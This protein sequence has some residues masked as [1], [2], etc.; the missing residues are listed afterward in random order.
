M[1]NWKHSMEMYI[2]VEDGSKYELEYDRVRAFQLVDI[3]IEC[4]RMKIGKVNCNATG[5]RAAKEISRRRTVP[6]VSVLR[7]PLE[8]IGQD[9]GYPMRSARFG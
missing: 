9:L 5:A 4:L 2:P 8:M 3:C 7:D 6:A 1:Q